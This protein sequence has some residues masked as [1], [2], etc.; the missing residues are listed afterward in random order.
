MPTTLFNKVLCEDVS[1][2]SLDGSRLKGLTWTGRDASVGRSVVAALLHWTP[3]AHPTAALVGDAESED[4]A[5]G[6]QEPAEGGMNWWQ[7]P[8]R[9][10]WIHDFGA[11]AGTH[12]V[13][14]GNRPTRTLRRRCG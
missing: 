8:R 4:P 5:S 2:R 13:G 11:A 12:L 10:R 7:P 14:P 3:G 6:N 9:G 1:I